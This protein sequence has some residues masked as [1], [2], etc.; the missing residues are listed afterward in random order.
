VLFRCLIRFGFLGFGALVGRVT[1]GRTIGTI[2][3][4][5]ALY[6]RAAFALRV[7]VDAKLGVGGRAF[8]GAGRV[9][10]EGWL[11]RSDSRVL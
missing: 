8:C 3:R 10:L 11:L 6:P 1:R 9:L 4:T 2:V 5:E 7:I